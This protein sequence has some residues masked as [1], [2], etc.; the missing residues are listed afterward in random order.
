MFQLFVGNLEFYAASRNDFIEPPIIA[1]FFR[2]YPTPAKSFEKRYSLKF[3]LN[4]CDVNRK[5]S[6]NNLSKVI[7]RSH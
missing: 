3:N 5:S 7:I 4:G 6:K 2:V 1:R